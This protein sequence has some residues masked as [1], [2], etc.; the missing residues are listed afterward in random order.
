MIIEKKYHFYA[1]HRNKEAGDK[2]GRLHGHTYSVVCWFRFEAMQNGIT[3]LFS[4]IDELVEP[5]VKEYDHYLLMDENDALC[6]ILELHNE[7]FIKLP[8]ATSAENLALWLFNRIKRET[9]LPIIRIS[10]AETKSSTVNYE[11]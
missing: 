11:A 6:P 9:D 2:C 3:M 8:F 7:Q 10:L 1:A 5:I 4:D